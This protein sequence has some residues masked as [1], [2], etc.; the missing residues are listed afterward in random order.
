MS[1]TKCPKCGSNDIAMREY[2]QGEKMDDPPTD[3]WLYRF[4]MLWQRDETLGETEDYWVAQTDFIYYR[5]RSCGEEGARR[6]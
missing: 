4:A 3:D 2:E 1:K 5:C 6:Q